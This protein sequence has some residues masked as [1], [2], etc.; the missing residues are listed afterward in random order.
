M[1]N[2]EAK[3]LLVHPSLLKT[4][5]EAAVKA[6]IPKNKIYQFSDDGE[7]PVR[8][9]IQ[10]WRKM[11]GTP[12]QG[13]R[14]KW[15]KLDGRQ[16]AS[17]VAT[18]NY[19]SGTTGLP[20]GVC[21][22]HL[23]LVSHIEQTIF[24]KFHL[25]PFKFEDRPEERW[26]GFLPLYHAYGQL[27][28]VLM[29]CKLEAAV[30]IMKQFVYTDFLAAIQ[31][32][33]ITTL[34]AAPPILVMLNKR[35]ETSNYD[36]SSIKDVL[37]GA[38]PLSKETQNEVA[39]KFNCMVC[40]GWGMTEVTCGAIVCPGG[41]YDDSGSVGQLIPNTKCKLVD[42]DEKEVAMG[43]PGELWIQGPQ[44]CMR[45]WKNEKATKESITP[46]GWLK[47]G[48]VAV[49]NDRGFF[50]IVDRK[51]VCHLCCCMRRKTN[52]PTGIDQSQCSSGSA[53][54][55]GVCPPGKRQHCRC[56][57]GRHQTSRGRIPSRIC[58]APGQ[59]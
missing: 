14:Y 26:I 9:G 37:V 35:P 23:N 2:T 29:A 28:A 25:K 54:R 12:E 57:G 34:Q 53:S 5:V 47:T 16:A 42:E 39:K 1:S 11:L 4:A 40:Q 44:V 27:Y 13:N 51:K 8:D 7:C 10:D 22:S 55:I 41:L 3:M 24:A 18:I 6:G 58:R 19:S 48:D 33:K 20:K 56:S 59:S 15:K 50:W 36:L 45:Y 32:Y 46:D 30:Y 49:C 52:V 38:A 31:K 43:Q 21:V 17:T